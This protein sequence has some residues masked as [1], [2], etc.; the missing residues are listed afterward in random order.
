[1]NNPT[2]IST[3]KVE[4]DLLGTGSSN[5]LNQIFVSFVFVSLPECLR[6]NGPRQ[7]INCVILVSNLYKSPVVQ[8]AV[9]THSLVWLV[10]VGMRQNVEWVC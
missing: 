5:I 4:L 10:V 2:S 8:R 7:G 3:F 6:R 9:L 1:M